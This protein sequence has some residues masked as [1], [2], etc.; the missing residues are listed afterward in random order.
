[1]KLVANVFSILAV[2]GQSV[3]ITVIGSP[4]AGQVYTLTC[5][6]SV[7]GNT[8]TIPVVTWRTSNGMVTSRTDISVSNGNLTFNPLRSSHGGQYACL[9]TLGAPF[10]STAN[11]IMNVIVQC[12]YTN[13]MEPL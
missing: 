10:N 12:M 3:T 7:V 13:I 8:S 4:L 9:S 2:L 1:M 11:T 6:G 5:L